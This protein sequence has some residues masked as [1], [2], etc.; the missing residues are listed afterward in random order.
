MPNAVENEAVRSTVLRAVACKLSAAGHERND[1]DEGSKLL[2]LGFIDSE[3]L[4]EIIFDVEAQC[5]CEF[6]PQEL[7]LE[8]GLTLGGLIGAFVAKG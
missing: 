8:T 3:D 2:E 7:D 4:I 1:I 5:G 6:D